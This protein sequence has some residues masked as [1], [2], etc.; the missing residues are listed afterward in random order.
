MLRS[1]L[2]GLSLALGLLPSVAGAACEVR[3]YLALILP[4]QSD[5]PPFASA[6]ELAYPGLDVNEGAG[7]VSLSGLVLPLGEDAGRPARVR[8]SDPSILEQFSQVYP[9]AFDL[10]AREVPWFDPGRT[11]HEGLLRALYGSSEAEVAASL[12][13]V[14]YNGSTRTARFAASS[15]QCAAQQLQAA[16]AAIAAEGP[17]L[18]HFFTE[19]GG[20]FI[21]RRIAGTE[22]HSAHSFGIAVDF[23]TRLGGYWRWSGATEGNVGPFDNRY[24]E[25]LVRHMERF[26]FIWGGKWH[27]FDGMHF[28][29][30][31]ELILHARL[32]H[33]DQVGP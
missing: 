5:R 19:V 21:W 7:T 2:V 22:R 20:S 6:L 16:L 14:D 9:L 18:D 15:R 33:D 3:D 8:L 25:A 10:S 32:L 31:P 17:G 26:G 1:R 12:L 11:R 4:H 24:P 13:R 28:E 27:H 30:R 23:N 29:Y